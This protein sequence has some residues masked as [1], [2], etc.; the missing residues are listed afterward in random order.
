MF[1]QALFIVVNCLLAR[2]PMADDD[3]L[4]DFCALGVARLIGRG[5]AESGDQEGGKGN[6]EDRQNDCFHATPLDEFDGDG[7]TLT[8]SNRARWVN[9][10]D[11]QNVG[12][13]GNV[14]AAASLCSTSNWFPLIPLSA[15]TSSQKATSI[16]DSG[17]PAE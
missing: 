9:A 4:N 2:H 12:M 7:V 17:A 16:R 6:N 10:T 1:S 3:H 13:K 11:C 15:L 5:A 8:K 14:D